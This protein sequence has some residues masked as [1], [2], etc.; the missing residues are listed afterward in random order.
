MVIEAKI[1]QEQAMNECKASLLKKL[2][3]LFVPLFLFSFV[4]M[5]IYK[6]VVRQRCAFTFAT[7]I[8]MKSYPNYLFRFDMFNAT[9]PH[10]CI[11]E[12]Y[13]DHSESF[14][15]QIQQIGVTHCQTNVTHPPNLHFP[16][17]F[18]SLQVY[19]SHYQN[20]AVL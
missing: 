20:A 14:R 16:F 5:N 9:S 15:L 4:L 17:V 3:Y 12:S 10:E 6:F 8:V 1:N 13:F 11:N 2:Y 19:N 18:C 7:A